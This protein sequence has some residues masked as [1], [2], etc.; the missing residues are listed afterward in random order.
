VTATECQVRLFG[1][2]QGLC[3]CHVGADDERQLRVHV[4]LQALQKLMTASA[5]ARRTMNA[6]PTGQTYEFAQLLGGLAANVSAVVL[7]EGGDAQQP[8]ATKHR[9]TSSCH[10]MGSCEHCSTCMCTGHAKLTPIKKQRSTAC[11]LVLDTT[12]PCV[13]LQKVAQPEIERI[14]ENSLD[15]I[16]EKDAAQA[17]A[18]AQKRAAHYGR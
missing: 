15:M 16:H 9:C 2:E 6:V 1:P 5:V 11:V 14:A 18:K 3:S 13:C 7:S 8:P 10:I 12:C 17:M 4:Q